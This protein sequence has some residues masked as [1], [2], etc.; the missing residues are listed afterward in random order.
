MT[1]RT[2]VAV[3]I[4]AESGRVIAVYFD[5][6]GLQTDELHRFANVPVSANGTLY[7][8]ILRLW[9]DVQT[10]IGRAEKP[11]SI[12]IDT[13]AID[14]ALLDKAGKLISNPVHY[15][16]RRTEGIM[17]EVFATVSRR[18]VFAATGIQMLPFNT[19]YQLVSMVKSR[20]SA[21][22]RA[23]SLLTI[24]D[25]L[26]FWLTGVKVNEYTNATTTQCFNV[27]PGK[28]SYDLLDKLDI[29]AHIFGE[30][31]QP[32]QILGN[33]QDIPAVLSAHHDTGSAVVG[34]P[35][36]S[37]KY[38]YLSSGTWSLLGLEIDQPVVN[39]AAL[40]A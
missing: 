40:T 22:Y 26:Y 8:D 37:K 7:W 36:Q 21:F 23:D 25:L 9:H 39:Q 30:V 35:V 6:S 10:G 28:W 19:L 2:V 29:P 1:K 20:D 5:G 27:G 38:A 3:D 15:R 32:G 11:A 33:Y 12:G 14:F 17:D 18:D 16:D 31:A 34:V 4:G 24:P 13:W